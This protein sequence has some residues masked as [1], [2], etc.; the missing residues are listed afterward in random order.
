MVD[1][2][3][4]GMATYNLWYIPSFETVNVFFVEMI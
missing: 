4:L 3:M 1:F 2:I